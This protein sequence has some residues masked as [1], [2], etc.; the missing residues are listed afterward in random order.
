MAFRRRR[1]N[2]FHLVYDNN[3][4]KITPQIIRE[5]LSWVFY[6]VVAIVIAAMLVYGFGKNVE[7]VG[8]SMEPSL[9]SG[10]EVLINKVSMYLTGPGRGDIIAFLPNG[11]TNS[12]YYVKR[13][14]AMPG[15][16]VQI[17]DGA[18]YVSHIT[19]DGITWVK[20]NRNI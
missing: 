13:V 1:K 11:N 12:H 17:I 6:T 18:L 19:P 16:T 8:D 10:Q 14:V 15:E 2:E 4:K 5:V 7:L 3:K 20:I 9:Y